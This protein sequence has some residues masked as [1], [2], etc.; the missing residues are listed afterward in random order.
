MCQEILAF[1]AELCSVV[2]DKGLGLTFIE[3]KVGLYIPG[4]PGLE[5]R[6]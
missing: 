4:A 6:L 1:I 5:E 3:N 2:S